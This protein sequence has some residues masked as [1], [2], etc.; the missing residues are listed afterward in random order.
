MSEEKKKQDLAD[1]LAALAAGHHQ[2]EQPLSG[3]GIQHQE[4]YVEPPKPI[5]RSGA[6][7][8]QQGKPTSGVRP[9]PTP[10]QPRPAGTPAGSQPVARKPA[11]PIRPSSPTAKPRPQMPGGATPRAPVAPPPPPVQEAPPATDP[12]VVPEEPIAEDPEARAREIEAEAEAVAHV[13]EDS[14]E[15]NLPA[16]PPEALGH[17]SAPRKPKQLASQ[18]VSFKQTMIPPLLTMGV[19]L[20]GLAVWHYALGEESPI[21]GSKLVPYTLIIAGVIMLIF[22]VITML[23]VR[24]QLAREAT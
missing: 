15:L 17:V 3:S 9:P 13:V 18:K 21:A 14:D 6:P 10:G 2:D 20:P 5:S 11:A 19:L 24:A 8:P 16:P 1:A 12:L 22:A 7:V 23:Q 4:Q